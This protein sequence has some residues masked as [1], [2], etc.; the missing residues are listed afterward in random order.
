MSLL[1]IDNIQT[2]YGNKQVLFDLSLTVERGETVLLAGSNGSGKSTLLKAI[3][4]LLPLWAGNIYYEGELIQTADTD[5]K[6]ANRHPLI[7]RGLVYIPQKNELFS[8]MTVAENLTMSLLHLNDRHEMQSRIEQLMTDI[9]LLKERYRQTTGKLSGGE[10]KLLTLGMALVNRPKVLLYDEPL[11]GLSPQNIPNTLQ[12]IEKLYG[13]GTAMVI[14]EH[15]TKYLKNSTDKIT[16]MRFRTIEID[17]LNIKDK[18][19]VID[20]R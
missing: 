10:A 2:G 9:P 8:D 7:S 12:W 18:T 11:A 14:V 13:Y 3:Y 16:S 4:G 6:I 5:R 20:E 15:R 17:S 1:Q 19:K